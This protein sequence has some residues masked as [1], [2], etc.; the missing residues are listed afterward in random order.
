MEEDNLVREPLVFQLKGF[1]VVLG[2]PLLIMLHV[3]LEFREE[4]LSQSWSHRMALAVLPELILHKLAGIELVSLSQ[5][6]SRKSTVPSCF[7]KW[8]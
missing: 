5:Y 3:I 8:N 2:S 4:S 7:W 6:L 1:K